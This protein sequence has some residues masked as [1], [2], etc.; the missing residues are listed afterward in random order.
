MLKERVKA[1]INLVIAFLVLMNAVLTAAGKNPLP[2]DQDAIT[3]TISYLAAGLDVIWVWWHNNNLTVEAATGTAI[4]RR[5]KEQ[6][7]VPDGTG[8]PEGDDAE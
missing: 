6:K 7:D 4:G 8:D 2:F 1:I 3:I 5:M